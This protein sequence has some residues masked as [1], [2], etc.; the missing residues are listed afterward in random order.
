MTQ[1]KQLKADRRSLL[2]EYILTCV[3][4]NV[5]SWGDLT[6]GGGIEKILSVISSDVRAV[7]GEILRT[8]AVN[9][10]KLLGDLVTARASK[11]R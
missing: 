11:R 9:G 7:A 6:G 5:L 8:G 1:Q 2:R 4:E 10:L 3:Q